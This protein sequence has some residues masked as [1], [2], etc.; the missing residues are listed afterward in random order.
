MVI[1]PLAFVPTV[2][3][4]AVHPWIPSVVPIEAIVKYVSDKE[5]PDTAAVPF[6]KK[7]PSPELAVAE[8]IVE[9]TLKTN[10]GVLP[11]PL[12]LVKLIAVS[13]S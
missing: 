7:P 3:E 9:G 11:V 12:V 5:V 6:V 8:S 4:V 10:P 1:R 13:E 2:P